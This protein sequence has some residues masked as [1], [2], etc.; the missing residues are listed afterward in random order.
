ME[1]LLHTARRQELKDSYGTVVPVAEGVMSN[2]RTHDLV[3]DVA[4]GQSR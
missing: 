1:F 2:T 3:R 4:H